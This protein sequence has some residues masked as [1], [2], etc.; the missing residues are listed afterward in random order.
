VGATVLDHMSHA[1]VAGAGYFDPGLVGRLVE[2]CD[3][4]A[5][6][7]FRDNLAFVGI[8][9]T[10]VWHEAFVARTGQADGTTIATPETNRSGALTAA[11]AA[12]GGL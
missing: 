7:G 3:K 4:L 5:S 8:L 10:Q 11:P 6:T 1:N 9:S 12:P 2:K